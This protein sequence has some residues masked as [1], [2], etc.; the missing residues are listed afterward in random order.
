M[1]KD[2]DFDRLWRALARCS[3][4]LALFL[5]SFAAVLALN[6]AKAGLALWG[7]AK[8]GMGGYFGYW[9]DRSVFRAEDRPHRL[10]DPQRAQAWQRR[11]WIVAAS[12]VAAALTP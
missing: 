4:L 5:V 7:L 11:S 1:S 6:P 9:I 8:L 2:R 12:I 10:S 3:P